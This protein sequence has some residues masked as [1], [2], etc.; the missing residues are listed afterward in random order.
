[1]HQT[2]RGEPIERHTV[3]WQALEQEGQRKDIPCHICNV[4]RD[5]QSYLQHQFVISH[6]KC[7]KGVL[8]GEKPYAV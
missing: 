5:I 3:R 7:V 2:K 8:V 4:K 1:V 6:N